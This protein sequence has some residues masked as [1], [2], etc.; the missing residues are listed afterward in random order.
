[1][2]SFTTTLLPILPILGLFAGVSTAANSVKLGIQHLDGQI[3]T[4][5]AWLGGKDP[6][7]NGEEGFVPLAVPPNSPCGNRFAVDGFGDLH[8]EGCGGDLWVVSVDVWSQRLDFEAVLRFKVLTSPRSIWQSDNMISSCTFD[9]AD[10]GC[11][12]GIFGF[13]KVQ[14]QFSCPFPI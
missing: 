11:G 5:G 8:F 6:C 4:T 12:E 3:A 1:M 13:G 14:Q 7:Y 10:I 9:Y 2:P